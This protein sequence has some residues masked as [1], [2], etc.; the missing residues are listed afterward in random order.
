M[1]CLFRLYSYGL[2]SRFRA[3]LF[4]DF[5]NLTVFD[6]FDNQEMYGLEKFWAYFHFRKDKKC[7]P[8]VEDMVSPR[9]RGALNKFPTIK[10]F[11]KERLL[12]NQT[13]CLFYPLLWD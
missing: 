6:Y 10:D 12:R 7:R 9:L 1:E 4:E 5:Q 13:V 3:D 8:E 2:E 11:R